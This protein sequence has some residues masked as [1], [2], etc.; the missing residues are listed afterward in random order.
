[1][2][3]M[4]LSSERRSNQRHRTRRDLLQAAARLLKS[5]KITTMAEVA[6]A[7][8]VSRATAYRYFP[9]LEALICEAPL[10]A[11]TP[12]PEMLF[13]NVASSDPVERA[14]KAERVLHDV[15]YRNEKQ[16]RAMLAHSLLQPS[17]GGGSSVVPRRQN[18][19]GAY[20][21]AALAPVKKRVKKGTFDR[22]VAAL[23]LVYGTES[24]IVFKDVLQMD[25]AKARAV[26]SWTVKTLVRGALEEGLD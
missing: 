18:R 23:S 3:V 8:E 24:M 19:R 16:L 6:D 17:N 20:I 2:R 15:T 11:A 12:D 1:M 5:G 22:L 25:E 10:E 14:V 26:K 21:A 7:A 13:A 4:T 9:S